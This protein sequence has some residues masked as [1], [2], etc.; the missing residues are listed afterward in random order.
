MEFIYK[1]IDKIH[2]Y[3]LLLVFPDNDNLCRRC[4][5]LCKGYVFLT[6]RCN[7]HAGYADTTLI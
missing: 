7:S 1:V 3:D 4:I 6:V 2:G 5:A